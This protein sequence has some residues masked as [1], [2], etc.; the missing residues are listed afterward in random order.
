MVDAEELAWTRRGGMYASSCRG[1]AEYPSTFL[2]SLCPSLSPPLSPPSVLP[3]LLPC[4]LPS[5]LASLL[6]PGLLPDPVLVPNHISLVLLCTMLWIVVAAV[7]VA[8]PVAWF[9]RYRLPPPAHSQSNGTAD[10]V[11]RYSR[12]IQAPAI[13]AV[14]CAPNP[15]RILRESTPNPARI[16]PESAWNGGTRARQRA[17][18]PLWRASTDPAWFAASIPARIQL[19]SRPNPP[20]IHPSIAAGFVP[21]C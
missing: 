21:C 18:R 16:H 2:S 12:P 15:P 9:Y 11:K 13:I 10:L 3:S 14:R 7:L 4:L 19:D 17:G 20:R 5:L 6:P 1:P 8:A